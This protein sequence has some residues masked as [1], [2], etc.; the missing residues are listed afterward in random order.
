LPATQEERQQGKNQHGQ[1]QQHG[2]E[3]QRAQEEH[4]RNSGQ[5]STHQAGPGARVGG[6]VVEAVD[7]LVNRAVP[8]VDVQHALER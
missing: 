3:K 8:G 7:V 4:G 2:H 6:F 5:D 1:E